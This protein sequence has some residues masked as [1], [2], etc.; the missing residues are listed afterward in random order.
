MREICPNEETGIS[1]SIASRAKS[2][3]RLIHMWQHPQH[4]PCSALHPPVRWQPEIRQ[5]QHLQKYQNKKPQVGFFCLISN[6]SLLPNEG[7]FSQTCA[8]WLVC[9]LMIF[10]TVYVSSSAVALSAVIPHLISNYVGPD[11]SYPGASRDASRFRTI[12]WRVKW[13]FVTS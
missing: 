5:L 4:L 7:N 11:C 9:P 6:C 2:A 3:L 12:S 8:L 10:L 13:Q 1:L